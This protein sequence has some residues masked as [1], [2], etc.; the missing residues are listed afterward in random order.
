[1][2]TKDCLKAQN[3][4][5]GLLLLGVIYQLNFKQRQDW[6][7]LEN[8]FS[9]RNLSSEF[10]KAGL[11]KDETMSIVFGDKPNQRIYDF[12]GAIGPNRLQRKIEGENIVFTQAKGPF[13]VA[14][15]YL[16]PHEV[17]FGP[18]RHLP[19]FLGQVFHPFEDYFEIQTDEVD[20]SDRTAILSNP[21]VLTRDTDYRL[22]KICLLF[23]EYF[24]VLRV[25]VDWHEN[26]QTDIDI[27]RQALIICYGQHGQKRQLN[28]NFT[29]LSTSLM[30]IGLALKVANDD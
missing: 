6:V 25:V 15:F 4:I 20:F 30:E 14:N 29:E 21:M 23:G 27:K 9:M 26:L 5:L 13:D 1:M 12:L 18:Y 24:E 8:L 2:L 22:Q 28:V 16:Y 7:T 11:I 17:D 19:P 10:R 3:G